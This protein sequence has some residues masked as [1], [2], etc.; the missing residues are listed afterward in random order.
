M[1]PVLSAR[2]LWHILGPQSLGS[3]LLH[4]AVNDFLYLRSKCRPY[5]KHYWG[6]Q[7]TSTEKVKMLCCILS[8]QWSFSL[9]ATPCLCFW[10]TMVCFLLGLLPWLCS[11]WLCTSARSDLCILL[12]YCWP[13]LQTMVWMGHL[14]QLWSSVAIRLGLLFFFFRKQGLQMKRWI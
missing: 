3:K 14:C 12:S 10:R 11:P 9:P 2:R 5:T 6:G 13:R 1:I 8:P 7:N 4:Q